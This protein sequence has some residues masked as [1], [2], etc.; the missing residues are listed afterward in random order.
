MTPTKDQIETLLNNLNV[1][2]NKAKLGE[3]FVAL[4]TRVEKLEAAAPGTAPTVDT[5]SGAGAFGK[6]LMKTTDQAGA[7]T[8][9]GIA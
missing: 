2:T 1:G 3:I 4:L 7:K 9:L 6:Q 8:L 5:L